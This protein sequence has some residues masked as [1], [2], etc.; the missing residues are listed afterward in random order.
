MTPSDGK[1]RLNVVDPPS[2]K[3]PETRL[4]KKM[5]L[6]RQS[7]E[8]M[9]SETYAKE[10]TSEQYDRI[11]NPINDSIL[12]ATQ[13]TDPFCQSIRQLMKEKK[14]KSERY[15]LVN[16]VIHKIIVHEGIIHSPI[17]VPE[18]LQKWCLMDHHLLL[19]H[20]GQKWLYGYLNRKFYWKNMDTDVQNIVASSDL[21]KQATMKQDQYPRLPTGVPLKPFD[22][23]AIDL[24]GPLRKSYMGN[25]YIPT[26]IDLF[27]GW[28]E[29]I[30]IPD[31]KAETVGLTFQ[32]VF[33][34]QHLF[35]LEI[36]SD[37]GSEWIS[38]VFQ[39]I[40]GAG[41]TKHVKTS[42]YTPSSNGKLE[43]FHSFLMAGVR[44]LTY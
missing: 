17:L 34:A 31:K 22:K 32:R 2:G 7:Q 42:S 14:T 18:S 3:G 6:L 21:C 24:V 27:S 13:D 20:V 15:L 8:E 26:M 35:P 9:D 40:L 10:L 4:Q 44:K 12:R 33:L 19:G 38:S 41:N 16:G 37:R 25:V 28:P 1:I 11:M 5:R 39:D 30:G 43:R 36:L 23:V 29:A